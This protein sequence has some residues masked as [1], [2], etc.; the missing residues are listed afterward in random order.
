MSDQLHGMGVFMQA[1][2]PMKETPLKAAKRAA[3]NGVSSVALFAVMQER[4]GL[5]TIDTIDTMKRY[6]DAFKEMGIE[7]W[8]WGFP[9]AGRE[10]EFVGAMKAFSD[11]LGPSGWILDPEVS[12]KWKTPAQAPAKREAA[13]KLASLTFDALTEATGLVMTSYGMIDFHTNFPWADLAVGQGCPQ[14]YLPDIV[15]SKKAAQLVNEGIESWAKLYQ[16]AQL[17]PAVPAFGE[18]SGA[19]MHDFLSYFVDEGEPIDGMLVWSWPQ[20]APD[21]WRIIKRWST[22]FRK[23]VI[24]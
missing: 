11:A 8:I 5:K 6:A 19:R 22:W 13:S 9:Y 1:L 24:G 17:I 20:I 3:E 7:V 12:Y 15:N 16:R 21:E 14:L 4:T 23:E 2:K 10:A 18:N